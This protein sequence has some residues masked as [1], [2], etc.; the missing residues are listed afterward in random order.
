L[1]SRVS[2][3]HDGSYHG[4]VPSPLPHPSSNPPLPLHPASARWGEG[5]GVV[6]L[7]GGSRFLQKKKIAIN[8]QTSLKNDKDIFSYRLGNKFHCSNY[9]NEF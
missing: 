5:R 4:P 8:I 2:D 3:F 9:I 6:G 1:S 7:R